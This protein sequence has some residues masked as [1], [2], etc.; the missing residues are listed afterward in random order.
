MM[1]VDGFADAFTRYLGYRSLRHD[2]RRASCWIECRPDLLN[3]RGELHAGVLGYLVDSSAG[4]VCGMA[5]V[6]AWIITADLQFHLAAP[7]TVGPVRADAT[8]VQAGRRQV[9]GE[10]VV[11]D[12]G[13]ADRVVAFGTVNH[14]VIELDDSLDVPHDMPVGVEYHSTDGVTAHAPLLQHFQVCLLA[15]GVVTLPIAGVAVNPLGILHGGLS[16]LLVE[17]SAR[18]LV[19][20]DEAEI[21]D[22]AIRFIRGAK[23]EQAKA[24]ATRMTEHAGD[25]NVRVE[26]TDES[27]RLCALAHAGVRTLQ[28]RKP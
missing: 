15:P 10:V 25:S 18:S 2:D 5:A 26:I 23:Q 17:Q 21:R 11:R 9:L 20:F 6:P 3:D 24:T 7:A 4:V 8:V 19:G 28:G 22:I 14:L 27:G 13:D 16:S 12:E 1:T